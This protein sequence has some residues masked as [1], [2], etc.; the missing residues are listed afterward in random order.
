MAVVAKHKWRVVVDRPPQP[1]RRDGVI[2]A[3]ARTPIMGFREDVALRIRRDD[4]GARI[5]V[6][7]ASRHGRHDFGANAA[8]IKGL[9]D[10]IDDRLT[11]ENEKAER[12][13]QRA[14]QHKRQQQLQK[15]GAKDQ[16]P[17]RRP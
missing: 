3:V 10:E 4:D 16:K 2:E 17:P 15:A 1:P 5:D 13:A 14:E 7:S 11:D 8:R 9:L 12:A 6:R